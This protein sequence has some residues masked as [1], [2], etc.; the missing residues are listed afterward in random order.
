MIIEEN[1]SKYSNFGFIVQFTAM[2]FLNESFI[3]ESE[4]H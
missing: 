1:S 3:T 4:L 2:K